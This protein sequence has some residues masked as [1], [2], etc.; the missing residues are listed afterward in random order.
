MSC[1]RT[2]WARSGLSSTPGTS[3]LRGGGGRRWLTQPGTLS[4]KQSTKGMEGKEWEELYHHYSELSRLQELRSRVK[5]KKPKAFW[6]MKA[7]ERCE[8]YYD[9]ARKEDTL[10]RTKTRLEWWEEHLKD[11]VPALAK[12][13]ECLENPYWGWHLVSQFAVASFCRRNA[14]QHRWCKDFAKE[15][16]TALLGKASGLTR[17][18]G[19]R[20]PCAHHSFWTAPRK[21]GSHGR[22]LFSS[23]S[24]R[25]PWLS[26][27]QRSLSPLS[28]RRRSRH[29]L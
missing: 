9:P 2:R 13:L 3:S 26:Q 21:Y 10:G 28:L 16:G 8:E 7:L 29:V 5:V 22:A 19:M 4:A 6:A 27:R 25:S 11:P 18:H 12:A 20:C 23:S 14:F 17:T 15:V 24:R 1:G